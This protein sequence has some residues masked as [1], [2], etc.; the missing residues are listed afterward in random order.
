AAQAG[1]AK[2]D[3][4]TALDG[5]AIRRWDELP[6]R[7]QPDTSGRPIA[8]SYVRGGE[9][10]T[11]SVRPTIVVDTNPRTGRP[12]RV[13]RL[14][15]APAPTVVRDRVGVGEALGEG[16]RES[17]SHVTNTF[18]VLGGLF[19]GEVSARNLGGPLLIAQ[20]SVQTARVGG[21]EGVLALLALISVNIAVLN[22][23]PVPVLDGGQIILNVVE[24]AIGR[25]LAP[26]VKNAILYVGVAFVV[27]LLVLTT[28]ND[29]GR[30]GEML[31]GWLRR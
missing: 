26:R 1:L 23:L 30:L 9:A 24:T 2:G 8:V 6:R 17:W 10:R 20:A 27:V 11:V 4:I 12:R 7:V 19:S 5:V 29:L 31:L 14:G 13:A 3:S 15:A 25:P 22:L 21:L 28:V 18:A 16:W